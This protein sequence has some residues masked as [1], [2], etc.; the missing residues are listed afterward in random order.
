MKQTPVEWL[1]EELTDNGINLDLAFEIIE[2]AKE[3]EKQVIERAV[4]DNQKYLIGKEDINLGETYY[5]N[6]F[7][8]TPM[9]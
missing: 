5:N 3:K 9:Q 8:Q 1:V 7:K 2:E 6:T 4:N